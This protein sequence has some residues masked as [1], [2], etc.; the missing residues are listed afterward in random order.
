MDMTRNVLNNSGTVSL[1]VSDVFNTRRFALETNG[2][3]F[4]QEREFWRE[5]RVL[6]LSFT[7]RFRD[8]RE[9]N[10]RRDAG[11]GIEGDIDGLF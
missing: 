10:G 5:S 11:N 4:Y 3:N 7:Y 1:N 2:T 6:T 9:R 8:F